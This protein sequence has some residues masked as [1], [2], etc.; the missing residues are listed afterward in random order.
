MQPMQETISVHSVMDNILR[1]YVLAKKAVPAKTCDK[2]ITIANAVFSKKQHITSEH[3]LARYNT[4]RGYMLQ[5]EKLKKIPVIV[6]KSDEWFAARNT[7]I[8][9]SDVAQ[10]IGKGKF[11]NLNDFFRKKC[12]Y[13]SIPFDAACPPLKHGCMYESVCC[14]I[15]EKR[16]STKVSEFGVL[17]HP[18]IPHIGASPDGI[19][20]EGVLLEIKAPY[21]R[22]ITGEVP[23]QY[24]YQVQFQLAVCDLKECDFAEFGMTTF[25]SMEHFMEERHADGRNETGIIGET[26]AGDEFTYMYGEIDGS[27]EYYK[28]WMDEMKSAGISKF[29]FWHL[30]KYNVVRI[31]R[32]DDLITETCVELKHVWDKV[33]DYRKDKDLYEAEV[34]AK[35]RRSNSSTKKS[36]V[37]ARSEFLFVDDE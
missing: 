31:Y 23:E 9:A 5:L 6:Q 18:T 8:S 25:H 20:S 16:N 21:R 33:C 11:G 26:R 1:K 29:H 4:L 12:A 22:K 34:N 24:A 35:K 17:R 3:V 14:S 32:D 13:E 28:K 30:D 36:V 10:A 19:T 2:I 15:Y 37:A 7:M 27:D